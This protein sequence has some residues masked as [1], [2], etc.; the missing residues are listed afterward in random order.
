M[1]GCIDCWDRGDLGVISSGVSFNCNGS[2]TERLEI[3]SFI[4]ADL[5][6]VGLGLLVDEE[7]E[8]DSSLVSGGRGEAGMFCAGE[9]M[10]LSQLVALFAV[11]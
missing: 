1:L 10:P 8:C 7:V 2:W 11:S 6:T 9:D 3:F 5:G 4:L